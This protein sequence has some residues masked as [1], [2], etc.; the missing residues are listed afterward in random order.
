MGQTTPIEG[1]VFS[2]SR[3]KIKTFNTF[4]MGQI[5][6]FYE[7]FPDSPEIIRG[8]QGHSK[9][10]KW[11][12]CHTGSFAINIINISEGNIPVNNRIPEKFVLKENF[13]LILEVAKGSATA[14][15]SLEIGS[16][17]MVFSNFTLEE[18]MNDDIRFPLE[19]W[20]TEW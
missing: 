4:D 18:S 20:N 19:K 16:K 10:K 14:F 1:S 15:K 13:P 6:R 11:F 9:E 5:V 2:D 3:G 7:I 17:L 8:W 12:Y